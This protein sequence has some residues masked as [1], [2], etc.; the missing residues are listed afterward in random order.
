MIEK[1]LIKSFVA[2]LP[3]RKLYLAISHQAYKEIQR[4]P[5]AKLSV[6]YYAVSLIIFDPKSKSILQWKR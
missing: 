1:S 6:E 5:L 3:D 4:N 2:N